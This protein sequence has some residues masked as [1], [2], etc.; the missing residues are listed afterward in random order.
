[1]GFPRNYH[2]TT[3]VATSSAPIAAEE[4]MESS[5]NQGKIAGFVKQLV[6]LTLVL[7]TGRMSIGISAWSSA[8]R[9]ERPKYEIIEKI[10]D[11][12]EIRKYEPYIVAEA[13]IKTENHDEASGSG[14]RKLAGYIFGGKQKNEQRT[15]RMTAPVTTY[16][17]NQKTYKVSFVMGLNETL[18]S[19]PI[20]SDADVSLKKV[21][22][23]TATYIRFSGPRPSQSLIAAKRSDLENALSKSKTKFTPSRKFPHTLCAGYH[24]PFITPKF[25]RRNEVGFHVDCY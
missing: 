14:F 9:L 3:P 4:M 20:P 7:L 21:P 5:V 1:M 17:P 19:L 13:T 8:N 16:A 15:M 11:T 24:D 6:V 2:D 18:K 25:L 10:G 12:V 23:H 22:A